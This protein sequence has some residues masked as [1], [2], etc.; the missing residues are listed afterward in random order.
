MSLLINL[1]RSQITPVVQTTDLTYTGNGTAR[2]GISLATGYTPQ[3]T[4]VGVN[5]PATF[6][7]GGRSWVQV[8]R[9]VQN[10][11]TYNQ[12]LNNAVWNKF[13][14][15]DSL[16]ATIDPLGG[17]TAYKYVPSTNNGLHMMYQSRTARTI[18]IFVKASGYNYA[19]IR[20]NDGAGNIGIIYC[21]LTTGSTT[22]QVQGGVSLVASSRSTAL[23]TWGGYWL[24]TTLSANSVTLQY[25][26]SPTNSSNIFAGN[27]TDGAILWLP[28]ANTNLGYCTSPIATVATAVTRGSDVYYAPSTLAYRLETPYDL[29]SYPRY[30]DVQLALCASTQ[31]NYLVY[32]KDTTCEWGV[33]L[34]PD[35]KIWVEGEKVKIV[36]ATGISGVAINSTKC[37]YSLYGAKTI[38]SIP[39]TGGS[40]TLLYTASAGVTSV[41]L[42]STYCYFT[43]YSGADTGIWRMTLV[44]GSPTKLTASVSSPMYLAINATKLY[45]TDYASGKIKS[46][47]LADGTVTDE[48]TGL[49]APNGL[50]I[51]STYAYFTE[52]TTGKI[53]KWPL[54]GGAVADVITGLGQPQYIA[55]DATKMYWGEDT[56]HTVKSAPLAGT[57]VTTI[58]SGETSPRG[59]AVSNK[60]VYV[61]A[62]GLNAL[63]KIYKSPAAS[64][65]L[66][67]SADQRL[68][69]SVNKS[70]GTVVLSGFTTGNQTMSGLTLPANTGN[71]YIGC[72]GNGANQFDG[73]V[74]MP[75]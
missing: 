64:T 39:L 65:A 71:V 33:S 4:S 48:V 59:L 42:D 75:E 49:T 12:A 68:K 40:P 57:P 20:Y 15:T 54:A 34:H 1:Q 26:V 37:F 41:A 6:S 56:G 7:F 27:G 22:I 67:W 74:S 17:N 44:G 66:T 73:V 32:Y 21:N 50:A 61:G 29:Y 60:N 51:D 28:Q 11:P 70:A 38:Y 43:I 45:W 13:Y 3:I 52:L 62:Y 5:V 8:E 36:T 18:G 25:G 55:V 14:V 35:K 63:D 46:Y 23:T 31:K 30:S 2:N 47:L 53:R 9:S 19:F 58:L 16:T 72:D 10:L 69:V 24:E